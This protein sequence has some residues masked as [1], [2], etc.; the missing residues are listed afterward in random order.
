L[1]PTGMS[2]IP[3]KGTRLVTPSLMKSTVDTSLSAPKMFQ[4]FGF[5]IV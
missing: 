4:T 2:E 1:L 3:R 5:V